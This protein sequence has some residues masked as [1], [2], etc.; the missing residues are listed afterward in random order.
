MISVRNLKK[1]FSLFAQKDG[2][3]SSIRNL[4]R[5][6]YSIKKAVDDISFEINEGEIVGYIGPNGAGKSTSIK[7][8]TGILVPTSGKVEVNGLIP[9]KN[10][11]ENAMQ[12]GVVIGQK[13]QLWWDVPVIE[14]LRLLKDI[15][16]IPNAIFKSNL[17]MFG[18]LLDLHQFQNTPVRQLS[19]GQRMRADLA[20]ALMHNPKILF[21]DEPTIGVDVV[22]K[23]KLRNF[24]KEIN[25]DR[26]VTVLL[27]THDMSDIEKLCSRMM[28]IDEG[29][30]IYDGSVDQIKTNYGKDREIVFDFENVVP[31]FVLPNATLVKSEVKRRT[32]KFNRFETSPSELIAFVGNKFP[33]VDLRIE[34]PEIEDMIRTIYGDK[35]IKSR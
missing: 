1:D 7:M 34:E 15:Y 16:K 21:L 23:E 14:S 20:A 32:F 35:G 29:K 26:K 31:N 12:I 4:F 19:L 9:Y 24:I 3:M 13:S 25:N 30:I 18:D 8:L 11:K 33:V 17:K 5:R 27:T 28:I 6:E 10:R 2:P 22:A